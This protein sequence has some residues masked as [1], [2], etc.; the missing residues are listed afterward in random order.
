[1][2][3][4]IPDETILKIMKNVEIDNYRFVGRKQRELL[5][6]KTEISTKVILHWVQPQK[7]LEKKIRNI[8]NERRFKWVGV[9]I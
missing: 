2:A 9:N 3:L 4:S 8:I 1:M 6:T 5:N 7:T